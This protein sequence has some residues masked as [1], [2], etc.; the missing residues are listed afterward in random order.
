VSTREVSAMSEPSSAPEPEP[1]VSWS[2]EMTWQEDDYLLEEAQRHERSR[3]KVWLLWGLGGYAGLHRLYL[4]RLGTAPLLGPMLIASSLLSLAS[5]RPS[6][7]LLSAVMLGVVW[8]VE[9]LALP[10]LLRED[11]ERAERRAQGRQDAYRAAQER[12]RA[13]DEHENVPAS[14]T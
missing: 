11:S 4:R 8:V 5:R 14:F 10:R 3:G 9:A 2:D 12:T 7:A 6:L 13:E 1:P